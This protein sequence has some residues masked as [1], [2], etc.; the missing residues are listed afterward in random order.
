MSNIH[1][2]IRC[3]NNDWDRDINASKNILEL[4]ICQYRGEERP[5]CFSPE[6]IA[7][8]PR[9]KDNKRAKACNSPLQPC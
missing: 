2:V 6:K 7:V 8:K 3:K 1:S 5:L 4:L 9:K